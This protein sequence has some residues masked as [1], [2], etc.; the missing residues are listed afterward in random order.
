MYPNLKLVHV[1]NI[2]DIFI[3]LTLSSD[4]LDIPV[5]KFP[6]WPGFV[7]DE[8]VGVLRSVS[9]RHAEWLNV[10]D[11]LYPHNSVKVYIARLAKILQIQRQAFDNRFNNGNPF[12]LHSAS[13]PPVGAYLTRVQVTEIQ[14]VL[15]EFADITLLDIISDRIPSTVFDD[16]LYNA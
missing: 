2:S 16:L 3:T 1:L 6:G 15:S 9:T 14:D 4:W 13:S 8:L 12:F 5:P 11:F 7:Q 10:N